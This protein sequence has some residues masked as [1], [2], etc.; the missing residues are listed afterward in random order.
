MFSL[1]LK[2]SP[3]KDTVHQYL[4]E[5]GQIKLLTAE[6]EKE[7]AKKMQQGNQAAK[8]QLIEANLR[9]V[10]CIARRYINR[11][12]PLSDLI[13]EGN[14]GLI[15]AVEKF[16]PEMGNRF[17]TYATWW[18]RQSIERALMSQTRV[19]RLPV[20][21]VKKQKQV[22]RMQQKLMQGGNHDPSYDDV[23]H[24]LALS[25]QYLYQLM[26][27]DKQEL[28]TDAAINDEQDL[29]LLETLADEDNKDPVD[30]IQQ[31]DVT[32]LLEQWLGMLNEREREIIEKR[33]GLNGHDIMT[34]ESVGES[35]QLT[36]ER[37]R[38]IQL[39][40]IKHLRQ[41]YQK[42]DLPPEALED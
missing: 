42:M 37:V 34:L 22:T 40:T 24:E 8:N 35:T 1:S 5:I 27:H 10:V 17:S 4:T 7:L 2:H 41:H 29:F 18:I 13:E 6:Q 3:T 26:A 36:R 30:L 31:E 33:Y 21:L 25:S 32:A 23:A 20:H 38:Q 16:D 12:L 14:L 19:V 9:L 28:S 11:G 15:H 39:Q